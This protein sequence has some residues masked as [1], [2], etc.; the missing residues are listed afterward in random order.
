MKTYK[1]NKQIFK[2]HK[3]KLAY[4][5][6]S[7][8][9]GNA[10][11]ESDYDIAVLFKNNPADLLAL[12]ETSLLSSELHKFI[13][14]KLDIV[15]LNDASLLLKYEVVAHGQI[16]YSENEKERINFEVVTTKEY[17]DEQH[18]RDIYYNALK[19]RVEKGV[20]K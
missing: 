4:L 7:Q 11:K 8:A 3:V 2:K 19:E 14:T 18:V 13:P 16:L 1:I 12:K 10:A 6:G 9:K 15:S 17:I 20:Y 5:F